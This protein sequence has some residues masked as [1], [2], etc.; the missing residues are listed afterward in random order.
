MLHFKVT[1]SINI[2]YIYRQVIQFGLVANVSQ[3]YCGG[4]NVTWLFPLG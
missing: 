1:Q 3:R 4:V 2:L